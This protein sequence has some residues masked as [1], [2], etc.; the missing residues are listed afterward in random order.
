VSVVW[1]EDPRAL[2]APRGCTQCG[3]PMAAGT[4]VLLSFSEDVTRL[5][6][7]R[8]RSFRILTRYRHAVQAECEESR[9]RY[10]AWRETYEQE[11][12]ELIAHALDHDRRVGLR[13]NP[14]IE[15]GIRQSRERDRASAWRSNQARRL[16]ALEEIYLAEARQAQRAAN[17]AAACPKP[18][19]PS[20]P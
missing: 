20:R 13:P 16:I 6:R 2:P 1:T 15:K 4:L 11:T 10:L 18:S 17:A 7:G 3:E 8:R 12:A 9:A 19:S 5:R 14:S